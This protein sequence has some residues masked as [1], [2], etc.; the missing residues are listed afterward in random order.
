MKQSSSFSETLDDLVIAWNEFK[1]K[2]GKTFHIDK[3]VVYI[4]KYLS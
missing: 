1:I 3:L 2:I 4:G